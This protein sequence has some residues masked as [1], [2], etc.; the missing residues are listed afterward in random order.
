MA[1]TRP[2]AVWEFY[3]S[4]EAQ[5]TVCPPEDWL[6]H[7]GTV[8][9]ARPGRRLDIVPVSD[10]ADQAAADVADVVADAVAAADVV[11]G[12]HHL[13]RHAAL[14]PLQL[15]GGPRRHSG[16]LAR[17]RLHRRRPGPPRSGR[18]PLPDRPAPRP[19]HQRG[20]QRLSRRD[21]E[22]PGRRRRHRRGGR[23]RPPRRAVG[24]ARLRRLRPRTPAP[25]ST[26]RPCGPPPRP[27]SPRT[28]G[29]RPTSP[30]ATCPTRPP[31]S[32]CAAPSPSTWACP[33]TA[34]DSGPSSG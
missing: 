29:P 18:L 2:G 27:A 16:G 28:S 20:C 7:P 26:R 1:R 34:A 8:G 14:R 32:S 31:G 17:G 25:T 23:L 24:P 15:L 3:G 13:V 12:R 19:H 21:R 5:F 10:E 9:R 33:P 30:P 4:T 22:R 6:E 11:A